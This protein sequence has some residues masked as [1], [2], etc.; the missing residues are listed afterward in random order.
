MLYFF[1]SEETIVRCVKNFTMICHGNPPQV[2]YLLN[3]V[4]CLRVKVSKMVN[5]YNSHT[6][7]CQKIQKFYSFSLIAANNGYYDDLFYI[8]IKY[9]QGDN[10]AP[11]RRNLLPC[12]VR[13]SR[14]RSCNLRVGCLLCS[15]VKI[16]EGNG[17]QDLR[18]V[19]GCGVLLWLGWLQTIELQYC[20][21][22]QKRNITYFF[23]N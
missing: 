8:C 2:K 13:T 7:L 23:H 4:G 5:L 6:I 3:S 14:Q 19:L 20:N 1:N 21:T 15:K 16:Y 10:L 11:N 18:K 17:S 12:A 22:Q 9:Q